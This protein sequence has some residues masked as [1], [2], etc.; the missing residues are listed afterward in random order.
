MGQSCEGMVEYLG[1]NKAL[2]GK[3]A[4]GDMGKK[5][6]GDVLISSNGMQGVWD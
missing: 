4:Q 5:V 2:G 1:G 6:G 3:T